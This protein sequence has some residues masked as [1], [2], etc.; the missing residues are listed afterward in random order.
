MDPLYSTTALLATL[1]TFDRPTAWLRDTFFPTEINFVQEEIA[2]DKVAK[3]R[4]IAPFV[5]P[6][7]PGKARKARGRSVE[8]F[9]PPYV[10]PKNELSPGD[11]FVRLA[12][13]EINGDLSP[14][15]RFDR[16]VMQ[17]LADQDNEVTRR[18]EWMCAQILTTGAVVCEGEDFPA[19]TVDFGR[20]ASL[21]AQLAGGDRWGEAGVSPKA[22]LRTWATE[23][24]V[25]AGG[26]PTDVVLG[27]EAA[28]LFTSDAEVREILDNRRQAGGRL[29][30]GPIATGAEDMVAAYLGSF[31]QF[32]FWQYTQKFEDEAGVLQ[33]FFPSYG[34]L[35]IAR[36]VFSGHMCYGA[37][38][39]NR[40]LRAM[41]RFPKTWA[42]E[43]PSVDFLMTQ[44]APL[45]VPTEVNGSKFVLVR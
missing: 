17:M 32:D 1:Q 28:E 34:C 16:N 13:E 15:E 29:E 33:D 40:A 37:I 35:T 20:D 43:D 38:K 24:S 26:N 11:N 9:A 14:E 12:G 41:S 30:M 22:N 31:G 19:Q 18:E 7:V 5:S 21:T 44:S 10:K 39:D 4:K 27:A 42:Q 8:S 3:R 6:H 36:P 25:L 23:I 2:F 45:P